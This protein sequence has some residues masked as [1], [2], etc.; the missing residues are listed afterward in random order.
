MLMRAQNNNARRLDM[1]IR[2]QRGKIIDRAF[3]HYNCSSKS[4]LQLVAVA[5]DLYYSR[6][7]ISER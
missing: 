4:I 3:G 2:S 1:D 5:E 7:A 6:F